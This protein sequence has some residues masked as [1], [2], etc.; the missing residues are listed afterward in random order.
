[1]PLTYTAGI[2]EGLTATATVKPRL[3]A[4][5]TVTV[6]VELQLTRGQGSVSVRA[7]RRCALNTARRVAWLPNVFDPKAANA[8]LLG[9]TDPVGDQPGLALIVACRALHRK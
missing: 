4:D 5:D 8:S 7:V 6:E 3:N 2:G 9:V 1:M